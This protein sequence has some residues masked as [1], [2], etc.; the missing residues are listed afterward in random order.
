MKKYCALQATMAFGMVLVMP[1]YAGAWH[2]SVSLPATLEYDSNPSMQA[3]DKESIWRARAMPNFSTVGTYGRDELT[4]GLSLNIERSTDQRISEARQDPGL[5]LG[6]ARQ[7]ETGGFGLRAGYDEV[8]T[9]VAEQ[10]ES[11]L[12]ST[13]G[14][15]STL[16]FGGDWRHALNELLMLN[17]DVGYRD[18]SYDKGSFTD[19]ANLSASVGLDYAMTERLTPFARL[20]ASRY[21]PDSGSSSSNNFGAV[22]GLNWTLSDQFTGSGNLGMSRVTGAGE[23]TGWQGGL[24]L[25]YEELRS[26]WTISLGRSVDAGGEGG[27]AETDHLSGN[28]SYSLD[29]KSQFSAN[30]IRREYRGA[31]PST[32]NQLGIGY[33]REISSFVSFNAG[34]QHRQ[35]SSDLSQ[36][37]AGNMITF[38]MSYSHPDL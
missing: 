5:S 19:Y 35:R 10:L 28:W 11:V 20:S 16:L 29:D 17:S 31:T 22:V 13:D 37:A 26:A 21:E 33:G 30:L 23:N 24:N 2:Q 38:S 14:T 1:V 18:V 12:I 32:Y 27:Y 34:V 4:A 25:R 3:S 8:S 15:R 9:R 7:T 6:W 36:D